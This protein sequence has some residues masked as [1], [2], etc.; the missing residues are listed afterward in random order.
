MET[1]ILVSVLST[2]GVVAIVT[3]IVVAFIKL[4]NKVDVHSNNKN[5]ES[6]NRRIDDVVNE[7]YRNDESIYQHI[8]N[9]ITIVN[10]NNKEEFTNV[11]NQLDELRRMVDSRCDKLDAK[12]KNI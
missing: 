9:E 12:I 3:S 1:V 2:L 4:K 10:N 11:Y 7:L 8:S 6:F 5:I